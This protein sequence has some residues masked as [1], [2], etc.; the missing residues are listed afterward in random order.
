MA[1]GRASPSSGPPNAIDGVASQEGRVLII[2]DHK[3][4][5]EFV[6]LFSS[7]YPRISFS[8]RYKKRSG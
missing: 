5:R 6:S 1:K 2:L 8:H 7:L 4:T 3:Q